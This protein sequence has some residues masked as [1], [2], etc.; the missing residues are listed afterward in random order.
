MS[1]DK[2]AIVE[3]RVPDCKTDIGVSQETVELMRKKL[4]Q[5]HKTSSVAAHTV[6]VESP[7]PFLPAKAVGSSP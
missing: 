2:T 7:F 1:G 5:K 3:K 4:K 6:T